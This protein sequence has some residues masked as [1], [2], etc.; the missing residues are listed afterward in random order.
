MGIFSLS[1]SS[2]HGKTIVFTLD[3][4]KETYFYTEEN[5]RYSKEA[6]V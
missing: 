5:K 2:L 4:E 1:H 3:V 6:D